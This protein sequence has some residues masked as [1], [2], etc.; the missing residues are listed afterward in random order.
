MTT[1]LETDANGLPVGHR[2]AFKDASKELA[3]VINELPESCYWLG[4]ADAEWACERVLLR[5][6]LT[7]TRVQREAVESGGVK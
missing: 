6:L 5:Y 3:T 1:H 2:E 7:L 4:P